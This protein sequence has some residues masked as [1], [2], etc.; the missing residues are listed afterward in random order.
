MP[1]EAV[2]APRNPFEAAKRRNTCSGQD[3]A[4]L[5][6]NISENVSTRAR[7][8]Q[9]QQGPSQST[10]SSQPSGPSH[11]FETGTESASSLP[12]LN[13]ESAIT[14]RKDSELY[15]EMNQVIE[16]TEAN[17]V[18]TTS[19]QEGTNDAMDDVM[20]TEETVKR[21]SPAD[22]TLESNTSEMDFINDSDMSTEPSDTEDE[23]ETLWATCAGKLQHMMNSLEE[24][25][26]LILEEIKQQNIPNIE[27]FVLSV[28]ELAESVENQGNELKKSAKRCL[29][30]IKK[31]K[32]TGSLSNEEIAVLMEHDPG[33]RGKIS[34]QNE[35]EFL[36]NMG[37]YQPKLAT[38]PTNDNITSGKHNRFS[39]QWYKEYPHL[40]NSVHN[41]AA[42]CF[43]CCLFPEG[44]GR[45][46]ADNSWTVNG[47]R[48]WH[49]MKSVGTKKKGK[50]AQHFTS[51]GHGEALKDFAAFVNPN[52]KVDTLLDS[53][54]RQELIKEADDATFNT[55]VVSI[56]FDIARTLAM[57]DIAFRGETDESSNFDQMVQLVSRQC[58]ILKYWLNEKR[59][60]PYHVT[61]MS[62]CS[63]NEFI[64][65]IGD[66]VRHR[67]V[68]EL[69]EEPAFSAMADTT[70]DVSNKDQMSIVVRYV[71]D[72]A[73]VERL[74]SLTVLEDKSGDGHATEILRCLNEHG[75]DVEKLHF[76]SY[77]FTACMS[78][79][80]NGCHKKLNEKIQKGFPGKVIPYI[81]CQAHRL[82]T[83]VERSCKASTIVSSMFT[84]LQ[85]IYS[86]FFKQ[87]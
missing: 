82:N 69:E 63:Q 4:T 80:Y 31:D 77:D 52:Q 68:K 36:I 46:S 83:F 22:I 45:V 42:F 70:P 65:L 6:R 84:V 61:Y 50:L 54:R 27:Q 1:F 23:L 55:R 16:T 74:L 64:K 30:K 66:A 62:R 21:K 34:S 12:S 11:E 43:V 2:G 3:A 18:P 73:P 32:C 8:H 14:S 67:I 28:S 20:V 59:M 37:P 86:F 25:C 58:T 87:H 47:V 29:E 38:F 85:L 51:Q 35:R 71:A 24:T 81:P 17:D 5:Q 78:G 33:K 44:V 10:E 9:H 57:Q 7:I 41:N 76:Q 56:L 39:S 26:H 13:A 19:S 48:Q 72:N 79:Q 15:D 75:I 60:Q 53:R 40:E 49:K